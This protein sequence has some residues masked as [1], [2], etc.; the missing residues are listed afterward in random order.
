MSHNFEST[1]LT[2]E[3]KNSFK[4]LNVILIVRLQIFFF[5]IR[6]LELYCMCN[7]ILNCFICQIFSLQIKV[8]Y[9]I[10]RI[11]STGLRIAQH[12]LNSFVFLSL[13]SLY[14]IFYF[15]KYDP[16]A[17]YT[18]CHKTLENPKQIM[19]D[20]GNLASETKKFE[21][22]VHDA[23]ITCFIFYSKTTSWQ[24]Q[25]LL[26]HLEAVNHPACVP[27]EEVCLEMAFFVMYNS[28]LSS[29][30]KQTKSL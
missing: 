21:T 26:S 10:N 20:I 17:A 8:I 7:Q 16:L 9:N 24:Q 23:K 15:N 6:V 25:S 12:F 5:P 2:F 30:G 18:S 11:K 13:F 22:H 4:T 14:F 19:S 3:R 29:C 27:R 28:S 1:R